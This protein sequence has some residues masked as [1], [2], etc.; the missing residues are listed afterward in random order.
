MSVMFT[1]PA[2][3]VLT[4]GRRRFSGPGWGGGTKQGMLTKSNAVT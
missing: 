1:L 4:A 2:Q 3:E